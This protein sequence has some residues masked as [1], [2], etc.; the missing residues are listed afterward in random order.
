MMSS[1]TFGLGVERDNGQPREEVEVA[2]LLPLY[3]SVQENLGGLGGDFMF[4]KL[5][6]GP[7]YVSEME[8]ADP[9]LSNASG[10][11]T[12]RWCRCGCQRCSPRRELNE[13]ASLMTSIGV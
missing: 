11:A 4:R 8:H 1:G 7:Y 10:D 6:N 12:G 2:L 13:H 5:D 3:Y 9:P